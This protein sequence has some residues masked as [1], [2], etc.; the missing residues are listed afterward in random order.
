[1]AL[2]KPLQDVG[3]YF[4]EIFEGVASLVRGMK[5]TGSYFVKPET[6]TQKYPENRATLKMFDNFK[7]ELQLIHDENNQHSCNVCNTCARKCPNGSI[8]VIY[9]KVEGAD[10][11]SKK[12]LDKYIYHLETCSFCGLC[13]PSC[14]E[15]A[16]RFDQTFEH[17]V[18][19]R[20]KLTKVLN[21][22]G[23]TS[24]TSKE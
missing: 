17:A 13:V 19:D 14:D 2:L 15:N 7:G 11:R 9:K 18:F 20:S 6:A 23:S 5:V 3:N 16:L 4:R 8:E 1:M 12:V 10:G 24:K 21:R 22:P